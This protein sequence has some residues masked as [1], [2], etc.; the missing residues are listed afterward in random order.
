MSSDDWVASESKIALDFDATNDY[1][2]LPQ[3][4]VTGPE[5]T[6]SCWFKVN[7]VT[8]YRTLICLAQSANNGHYFILQTRG[9]VAGDP[10]EFGINAGAGQLNIRTP[11]SVVSGKWM[12][13]CAVE[14]SSTDHTCYLDFRSATSTTSRSPGASTRATIGAFFGSALDGYFNGQIDDVRIYNRALTQAEVAQLASRRGIAYET[15][16]PRRARLRRTT[17]SNNMLVGCGL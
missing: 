6:M 11:N 2:V 4:P 10:M 12:H 9:D 16:R 17:S 15:T 13:A 14:K 1:V 3:V 7:D 5:F 8:A